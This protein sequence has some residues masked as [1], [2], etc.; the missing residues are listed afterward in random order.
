MAIRTG[1]APAL[2]DVA[3]M[4]APWRRALRAQNKSPRTVLGYLNGVDCFAAF[5]DGHGLPG[6]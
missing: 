2:G 5:L 4:A 3:T 1:S 6:L